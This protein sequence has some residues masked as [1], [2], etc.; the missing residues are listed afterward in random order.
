MSGTQ[1][2]TKAGWGGRREGAGR[3]RGTGRYGEPTVPIRVPAS[4]EKKVLAALADGT[5]RVPLYGEAVAAGFPS[6]AGDFIEKRTDA[7]ALLVD[8]PTSTFFVRATGDS[9]TGAG[10]LA[11]D[12]LVVDTSVRPAPGMIVVAAVGGEF[13]VKRLAKRGGRLLLRAE[14]P[15]YA[16][17]VPDEGEGLRIL[18]VVRALAR[19][20]VG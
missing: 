20:P 11:G 15:K 3:P 8:N 7:N 16:D 13:T 9:M 18:G 10:I 6:P 12:Y 5:F 1:G 17:V 14:N 2:R 19:K 4:L